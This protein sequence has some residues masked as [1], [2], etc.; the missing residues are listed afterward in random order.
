M[1]SVIQEPLVGFDETLGEFDGMFPSES[2]QTSYIEQFPWCSIRI[3]RIKPDFA[4]RMNE[5]PNEK[6]QLADFQIGA[7]PH[8]DDF[9]SFIFPHQE[10]ARIHQIIHV[11]EFSSRRTGSPKRDAVHT[12]ATGIVKPANQRGEHVR[13]IEIEI[14]AWPIQIRG[15]HRDK[16]AAVL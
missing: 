16:S 3:R 9:R 11:Q 1:F 13:R 12:L 4:F 15:H 10:Q 14:V 8:V 2:V 6:C 7:R 5:V